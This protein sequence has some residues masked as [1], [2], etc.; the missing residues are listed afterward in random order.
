[1]FGCIPTICLVGFVVGFFDL[2]AD[3]ATGGDGVAVLGSPCADG[4]E[5]FFASAWRFAAAGM[6]SDFRGDGDAGHLDTCA[7]LQ[8]GSP[9]TRCRC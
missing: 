9:H 8:P 6:P 7:G 2:G 4:C 3:P 1:M 5:V